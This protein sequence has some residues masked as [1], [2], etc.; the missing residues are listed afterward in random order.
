MSEATAGSERVRTNRGWGRLLVVVYAIFAVS[1]IGRSSVQLLQ[2]GGEAPLAYTLS[3][4]AA[5]VYLVATLSL[6]RPGPRATR[7]AWAAVGIELVGVLVI[8]TLS[9]LHPEYFADDTVWSRFGVGYGYVPLVLPFVGL[10]W[11]AATTRRAKQPRESR[12]GQ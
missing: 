2:K 9:I 6:A 3:A 12:D 5:L 1:A 10:A 11:L 7:V 8:G 4:L